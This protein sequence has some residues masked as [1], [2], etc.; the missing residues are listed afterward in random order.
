M[1]N[2]PR[3]LKGLVLA[4]GMLTLAGCQT[5][6]SKAN[7]DSYNQQFANG[8][9]RDAADFAL[10]SGGITRAKTCSGHFRP[11]RHSAPVVNSNSAHACSTT[12]KP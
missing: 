8:Q 12:P 5:L 2:H 9:Y 11:V 10:K 6:S 7:L 4:C 1:R 3:H